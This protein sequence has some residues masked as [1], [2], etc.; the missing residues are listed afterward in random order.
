M[1]VVQKREG[2]NDTSRGPDHHSIQFNIDVNNIYAVHYKYSTVFEN[3]ISTSQNAAQ[4]ST[5]T[6]PFSLFKPNNKHRHIVRGVVVEGMLQELFTR[7][8]R[9]GNVAYQVDGGLIARDIPQLAR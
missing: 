8:L 9:V 2:G 3:Y 7:D 6:A 5:T 4:N 1:I